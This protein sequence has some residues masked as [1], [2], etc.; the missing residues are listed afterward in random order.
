VHGQHHDGAEQ[1][2]QYVAAGLNRFHG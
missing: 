2:K 1:D